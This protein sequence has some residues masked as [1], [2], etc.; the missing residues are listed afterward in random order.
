MFGTV[1]Y[2]YTVPQLQREKWRTGYRYVRKLSAD[3]IQLEL[4]LI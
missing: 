3:V 2:E 1:L 4:Q